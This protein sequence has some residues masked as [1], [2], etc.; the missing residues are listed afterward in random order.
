MLYQWLHM[1]KWFYCC[2]G[3]LCS[4][5][6]HSGLKPMIVT[7]LAVSKN[8]PSTYSRFKLR[9]LVVMYHL[10]LT[11]QLLT[12]WSLPVMTWCYWCCCCSAPA[13]FMKQKEWP[14]MENSMD[15]NVFQV[16]FMMRILAVDVLWYNVVLWSKLMTQTT[17]WIDMSRSLINVSVKSF[18]MLFQFSNIFVCW[19]QIFQHF[20]DG[21]WM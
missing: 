12:M 2:L 9:V 13:M 17:Y 15:M 6:Y 3:L 11:H 8:Q 20:L 7:R 1:N 19:H 18:N 10:W 16:H 5:C 4:W 21:G 14:V